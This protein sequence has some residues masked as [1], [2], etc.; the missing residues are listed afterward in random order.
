[1]GDTT[2][3]ILIECTLIV[4]TSIEKLIIKAVIRVPWLH[5][6]KLTKLYQDSWKMKIDFL[7]SLREGGR[8]LV[9][10]T[11]FRYDVH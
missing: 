9:I 7:N 2:S 6:L 11:N 4:G 3:I 8:K 5:G 10:Q 1:M